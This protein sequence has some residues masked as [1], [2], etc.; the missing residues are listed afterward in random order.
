MIT[1]ILVFLL[2]LNIYMFVY[3]V[4]KNKKTETKWAGA[5]IIFSIIA[6]ISDFIDRGIY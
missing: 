4:T 3:G 1:V 5:G 2:M 6:I